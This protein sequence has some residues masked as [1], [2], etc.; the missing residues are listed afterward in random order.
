[1]SFA[2]RHS[3]IA[4][5][6]VIVICLLL[7]LSAYG[8]EGVI[9]LD[10]GSDSYKWRT[11]DGGFHEFGGLDFDDSSW[12]TGSAAFSNNSQCRPPILAIRT[13]WKSYSRLQVRRKV[14]VP[15]EAKNI[16]LF[17]A[18]DNN[19]E[20][21]YFNGK[22]LDF[23]Y[24]A[25]GCPK[26]DAASLSIP[27]EFVNEG[28]NLIAV[29]AYDFG[30]YTFFD[31]KLTADLPDSRPGINGRWKFEFGRG[32]WEVVQDGNRVVVFYEFADDQGRAEGTFVENRLDLRYLTSAGKN[33]TESGRIECVLDSQKMELRCE[34]EDGELNN[35]EGFVVRKVID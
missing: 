11:V 2:T 9:V 33:P 20:K 32:I 25:R 4:T 21:V 1:M 26:V 5:S 29:Q 23:K 28:E 10:Y 17:F 6:T 31:M 7:A 14:A 34:I 19:I 27:D 8:Q 12:T 30:F 24:R 35:G 13:R 16:K 3:L 15:K 18:V 22:L